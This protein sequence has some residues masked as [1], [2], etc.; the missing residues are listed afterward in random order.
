MVLSLLFL[1]MV[2]VSGLTIHLPDQDAVPAILSGISANKTSP[3]FQY[4]RISG[5]WSAF[6]PDGQTGIVAASDGRVILTAPDGSFGMQFNGL[7]RTGEISPAV[8]GTIQADRDRLTIDRGTT[9]EW[10]VSD[11]SGIEQGMTI[12]A[13]PGGT[14]PLMVN[15]TLTGGELHPVAAGQALTF[16]NAAGPALQ[17]GSLSAHDATGRS[18]PARFA[19]SGKTLSWQIDDRDAIY[20]VTIDPVIIPVSSATARF[21]GNTNLDDFGSSV[22]LTSDGTMVLVGLDSDSGAAYIFTMP[23]GGWSGT[24]SSSN[25]NA[26]FSGG[27][28]TNYF[29][30]SVSLSSNGTTALIGAYRNSTAFSNAGAAYIFTMPSGGWSGT[31]SSSNANATLL[32]GADWDYFGYSV[33]LS[34]DGSTALVG[35]Y[36]NKTGGNPMGGAAY[37]FKIPAGG[38][39]G[40]ISASDANATF[41]ASGANNDLGYSVALSSNGT[42]ALVGAYGDNTGGWE[43]GAAYLFTMPAGGWSGTTSVS[44]AN[45]TFMGGSGGDLFGKSVALSSDGTTA[46]IGAWENDTAGSNSGAA[47][48]FTMPAGGWGGKISSSNANATF[49]GGAS[50]DNFGKSLALTSNGSRVLIGAYKNSTSFSEAGAAY[51]F[52]MPSGGWSGKTSASN[53]DSIFTGGASSDQFGN[54]VAL[55]SNGTT[56]IIGAWKNATGAWEAGATYISSRTEVPAASFTSTNVSV[57]TNSTT[58]GWSGV[59]PFTMQ[60]TDTSGNTPTSWAWARNNLTSTSWTVFNT[61]QNARDSFWTGNWSVNLTATNSAGS[62]VSVQTLWVNVTPPVVPVASFTSA[63]VSVATNSTSQGW[64]GVNPFTMQFTDTS[65]NVPTSWA[66]ARNNLTS[67]SWTVF[68]TSQNAQD[69]FWTGNW[70]VNLTATNS[71]GGNISSQT[72]WVNVSAAPAA[73]TI[74]SITPSSGQ[75]TTS[76]SITNLAGS[77][78]YG[79]PT[80]KLIRFGY[81]NIVATSVTVVSSNQMTCT[82]DLTNKIS[83]T[84]N[85]NVVNPDNQATTLPNGFTITNSSTPTPTPTPTPNPTPTSSGGGDVGPVQRQQSTSSGSGMSIANGAP[86][87]GTVTYSFGEPVTDYPV[88]IESIAFVPDQSIGQS[89]CLVTRTS[90]TAGFTVPDRPAVYESIQINW[91]NPNVMSDA[92]I[93]F[94]VRGSWMREHNVGPQEIVMMRQHDLVWAEIPTVYDH[95]ANDIYYFRA[96]TPGFSNFAVSVRK[97]M[98]VAVVSNTTTVPTSSPTMTSTAAITSTTGTIESSTPAR[99]TSP[100]PTPV[101]APAVQPE[102]GI[103][104]LYIIA[105]IAIIILAV[106]GFFIG[107]RWWIRRQNPALFRKYD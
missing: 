64:S 80:V 45:A 20:P 82:F 61:S 102:T 52:T 31:T 33:A 32:G 15:F 91:I 47:Y 60:F 5:T 76:V 63:N 65:G 27:Q 26:T 8:A 2:P 7:G 77:G 10:Y 54:S 95:V 30:H 22:S 103:P 94:S 13:R 3:A 11:S 68:N 67:Q 83:G 19:L 25:A 36:Y 85:V 87:G 40:T 78:F 81:G 46:L 69:G 99:Q 98:T 39:S 35:A 106:V 37:L 23:A 66:W 92:T 41:I 96:T 71:A 34:S 59:S 86:A 51:N 48:I 28:V 88:S 90:P 44:N 97:N 57:V 107:R 38:W 4:D 105:G 49:T 84:W 17:Y 42:T 93:Q 70:S 1:C 18:L 58:Q 56:S 73:P 72:L 29:G 43:T 100:T 101:P 50:N 75:N 14:G 74:T 24:T 89:Q 55:S 21:T 104:V 53:A 6:Q 16:F 9:T 79:T 12:T 62:N